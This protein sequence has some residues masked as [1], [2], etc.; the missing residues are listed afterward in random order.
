M[1]NRIFLLG[2]K[3][4]QLILFVFMTALLVLMV[5]AVP[6][7]N[8]NIKS[9]QAQTAASP[10]SNNN[11]NNTALSSGINVTKIVNATNL[12]NHGALAFTGKS[13]IHN[14]PRSAMAAVPPPSTNPAPL[15]A[16]PDFIKSEKVKAK[17]GINKTS[18]TFAIERF[19]N[20]TLTPNSTRTIASLLNNTTNGSAASPISNAT[21][22]AL[23]SSMVAAAN[24]T[25]SASIFG[26]EGINRN[27]G[28]GGSPSDTA[29]AA[30]QNRIIEMVN[31]RG[32]IFTKNGNMISLF[33]LRQLFNINKNNFISDPKILF[34]SSTG[35]WFATL[36]D[37]DSQSVHLAVSTTNDPTTTTWN[38][39][40]FAFLNCPDQPTIGLSSDKVAISVNT[41]AD[42]CNGDFS[43][44]Q[45]TV[46]DKSDLIAGSTSPKFMQ[47]QLDG[48]QFSLHPVHSFSPISTLFMVSLNPN[49]GNA[50]RLVALDGTAPNVRVNTDDHIS[51]LHAMHV[52]PVATQ[53]GTSVSVDT[54][55]ARVQDAIWRQ[56]KLWLTANNGCGQSR[57][58]ETHSCIRVIELDTNSKTVNQDFDIAGP[59]ID[60]YYP[61]IRTDTSGN[62]V[63][64][65]MLSSD[66]ISQSM[67]AVGKPV[68]GSVGQPIILRAGTM[69][70]PNS[71]ANCG[72]PETPIPCVRA[73]DYSATANDPST[74]STV[75]VATMYLP[76]LSWSTYVVQVNASSLR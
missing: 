19:P 1:P 65:G 63:V 68:E 52:P 43:G 15:T 49:G 38:T 10:N 47:S 18:S 14:L 17:L 53:P 55:D 8:Y 6:L 12:A 40:N 60:Y 23:N 76:S 44:V 27:M 64:V 61:S 59:S 26:F 75:W 3:G 57:S 21:T 35:R 25:R 33:S 39:Y 11:N 67:M 54:G 72:T 41:Y 5:I 46:V 58:T 13:K 4:S 74:P 22:S 28:G 9:A 70:D 42:N 29:L 69:S 50:V 45:Y 30:S 16:N 24:T 56:G 20:S 51:L 62:L 73:G 48:S 36:M 71:N 66:R 7:L 32:E 2:N 34:D 37:E 31:L